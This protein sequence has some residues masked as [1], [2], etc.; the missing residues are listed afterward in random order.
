MKRRTFLLA[1]LGAGGALVLGWAL[2]P[3]RQRLRGATTPEVGDGAIALNGWLAIH[4]DGT[5]TVVSP[6]AEMGQGIHTALA[7]LVAEELDADWATVRVAHSPID[8]IYGNIAVMVDGL[9]FHPDQSERPWVRGVKWLTAKTMRE[10]GVMLTG[11]S[12]SVRDCWTVAREAGATARAALIAE[13]AA[14]A[15]VD[16]TACRTERGAVLVGDRRIGYGDLVAGAAA[17]RP[18]NVRLK[19]PATFTLIGRDVVRLDAHAKAHG[20][21][22]YGIDVRL[23]GMKYAAVAMAPAFGSVPTAFDR[24]VVGG[25]VHRI[26]ALDGSDHGDPAAVAVIADTWWHARQALMRANITWSTSPHAA[27]DS[28]GIAA[29]LRAAAAESGGMPFRS[30][31]D[32]EAVLAAADRVIEA[33]YEAPYLAHAPMEPMNATVRV[34][35]DGAECWVGT[36]APGFARAAIARVLDIDAA[37]VVLHQRTLGGGFGRR[38]E[39]DHIAQAAAIARAMPDVPVQLI[40][41][42]EDDLRHDFHRPAA[43]TRLRAAI[44]PANPTRLAAFVSHSA[45]QSPWKSYSRRVGL[46]LTAVGP[47][48]TTAE[49]TWDQ[50]YEFAALRSSHAEVELPVPVG[51]W[52]S[53]GHS[54]QAFFLESFLD[55]CAAAA[56]RD[57]LEFRLAHL[58]QHPRAAAVLR[59]AAEKAG[60]RPGGAPVD[61][62]AQ[63][64]ALHWSFQSLVAE[65]AEVS[66]AAEGRIRVHRVVCAVDCGLPV[67]PDG[68]RQQVEGSV[69]FGLSA[70]LHGA[71]TIRDGGVTQ[72]N[73]HEY[74]LLRF[75]EAP[76]IETHIIQS[77]EPPSGIG[78]PAVP[79]VAPAVANALFALTGTRLRSLPLRLPTGS[80]T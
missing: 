29:T 38:L 7:M 72:G 28:A 55:E 15:G 71:I 53:V 47:D 52:R 14:R 30:V 64:L 41:A 66:I 49:G 35:A 40:W 48:K 39:V 10:M 2:V 6:K 58:T 17:R 63:G 34:S 74:P 44:D 80:A 50:P 23:P 45:S 61:G 56:G 77:A 65:V 79:P 26:V 33:A 20:T 24:S 70:A 59:L 5:V 19:D 43:A 36:Q 18:S 78:E 51:S 62:V 57:P 3:P 76:V 54:H 11:G 13:A 12:S 60:W 8:R 75:D 27:L 16:P 22:Q 1:G 67:H 4:P 68:I 31:G 42:R 25:P 21:S 69:I 9:P 32:A 73:F 37:R 46:G